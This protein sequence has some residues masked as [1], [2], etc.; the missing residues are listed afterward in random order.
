MVCA[1]RLNLFNI[2]ITLQQYT[3]TDKW[4]QHRIDQWEQFPSVIDPERLPFVRKLR[5]KFLANGTGLENVSEKR[6]W[7]LE[8]Y[9]LRNTMALLGKDR[10]FSPSASR[11]SLALVNQTNGTKNFRRFGKNG[12]KVIP[13]KV[14]L[15]SGKFPPG[16]TVPFEF[17]PE[18]SG[19][20]YKCKRSL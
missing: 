7:L 17:S 10:H 11:G 13:R 6:H 8:L 18:L 20:P 14:F 9:H 2:F 5:Q 12:K 16:W 3:C 4:L 19:F 1:P 15:F